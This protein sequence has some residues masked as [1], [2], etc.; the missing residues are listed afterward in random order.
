M[1]GFCVYLTQS[2]DLVVQEFSSSVI[3]ELT[4]TNIGLAHLLKTELIGILPKFLISSDPDVQNNCL[5]V[6]KY[7][8]LFNNLTS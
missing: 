2:E 1:I 7:C 6:R 5:Q 8:C 3:A 4:K